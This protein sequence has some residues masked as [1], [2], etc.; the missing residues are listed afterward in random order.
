MRVVVVYKQASDHAREVRDYLRDYQRFTGKVI[1]EIDPESRDGENFCRVYG[2]VEYPT[3]MAVS[4]SGQM[5]Q[6]WRGR[7]LPLIDQVSYYDR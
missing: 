6:M 5:Q 4:D 2:I 7:P 1:E 3:L